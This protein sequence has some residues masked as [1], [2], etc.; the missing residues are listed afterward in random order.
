MLLSHFITSMFYSLQRDVEEIWGERG[1]ERHRGVSQCEIALRCQ[2]ASLLSRYVEEGRSKQQARCR[3]IIPMRSIWFRQH[4]CEEVIRSPQTER[5][6]Q[7]RYFLKNSPESFAGQGWRW[8]PRGYENAE[9]GRVSLCSLALEGS[10]E[11]P[12]VASCQDHFLRRRFCSC[13]PFFRSRVP[14]PFRSQ[15]FTEKTPVH[16]LV[17]VVFMH[18]C[19]PHTISVYFSNISTCFCNFVLVASCSIL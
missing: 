13:C 3:S 12:T 5:F 10:C 4:A 1:I 7:K 9:K 2:V 6:A 18:H 16:W 8:V 17:L 19:W 15:H 14:N 11:G